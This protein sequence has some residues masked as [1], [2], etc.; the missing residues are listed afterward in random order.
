MP[1]SPI[2]MFRSDLS[3]VCR[4][5]SQA[6]NIECEV[7]QSDLDFGAH[8]TD[9][10]QQQRSGFLRLNAENMFDARSNFV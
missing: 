5:N 4:Q 1:F 7:A 2:A 6:M 10:S 9:G 8:D 3:S